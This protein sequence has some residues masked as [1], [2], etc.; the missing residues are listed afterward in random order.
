MNTEIDTDQN[1]QWSV[2]VFDT[3]AVMVD[4]GDRDE[5]R[6]KRFFGVIFV[7]H[8]ILTKPSDEVSL[9][10]LICNELLSKSIKAER[11]L[12]WIQFISSWCSN[13]RSLSPHLLELMFEAI[14]KQP[15]SDA[16]ATC[17]KGLEQEIYKFSPIL[18]RWKPELSPRSNLLVW[19]DWDAKVIATGLTFMC[20]PFYKLRACE[21]DETNPGSHLH[22]L[23]LRYNSVAK[24]VTLTCLAAS[25]FSAANGVRTM[26]KWLDVAKT[27]KEMQNYHMLFAI[28]NGLQKHQVDRLKS[29]FLGLSNGHSRIKAKIDKLFAPADRMR[30]VQNKIRSNIL[31]GNPVIPCIFWLSQKAALLKEVPIVSVHKSNSLNVDRV[32]AA[33]NIFDDLLAMQLN[34]FVLKENEQVLWYLMRLEREEDVSEEVLYNMS[35]AAIAVADKRSRKFTLPRKFNLKLIVNDEVLDVSLEKV[36]AHVEGR[37]L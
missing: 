30:I 14:D 20:L 33:T 32:V 19:L 22:D 10:T 17:L 12:R 31:L 8:E 9:F 29:L 1:E 21:F 7:L 27:L 25:V 3:L 18:G 16:R 15:E 11:K 26:Q 2:M 36:L 4:W 37:K 34:R 35:D 28:Q 24:F 13:G 6:R 5:L 23:T